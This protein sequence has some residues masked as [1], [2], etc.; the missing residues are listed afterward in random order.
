MNARSWRGFVLRQ[1]DALIA[2]NQEIA[3]FFE[4]CGVPRSR[5]RVIPPHAPV[6][7]PS[8]SCLPA[9]FREFFD[10]HQPLLLTVSGLEPE[11][12]LPLQIEALGQ[13]RERH[14]NAGLAIIG[15]GSLGRSIEAR[16]AATP[17]ASH[18][19][20]CG[21]VEHAV[22]LSAMGACDVFLRT[23]LYDGDSISVREALQLDAPVIAT[24]NGM[25]PA[26]CRLIPA[27]DLAALTGAIEEQ[28]GRERIRLPRRMEGAQNL[29]AVLAV[30][31]ELLSG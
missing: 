10:A 24:D 29:E 25:R 4:K 19:L 14:P 27:G 8:D 26:G 3:G 30:Y 1:F 21:D 5:I 6:A 13:V 7:A 28:V 17:Y 22:T 20:L 12:D 2:V 18:I 9:S 23:T 15:S 31:Q 16:I 11:Y